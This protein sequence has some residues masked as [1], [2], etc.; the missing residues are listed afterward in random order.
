MASPEAILKLAKV[1][2]CE[3][4]CRCDRELKLWISW[5]SEKNLAKL[6]EAALNEKEIKD[7]FHWQDWDLC[8]YSARIGDDEKNKSNHRQ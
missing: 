3:E 1:G 4:K 2:F 5:L 7:S 6:K 8:L